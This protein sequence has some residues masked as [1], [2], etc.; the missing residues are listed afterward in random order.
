LC[1]SFLAWYNEEHRHSWIELLTPSMVHYGGAPAV[2]ERR[3][4]VFDAAYQANPERS[5]RSAPKSLGVPPGGLDQQ[6]LRE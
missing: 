6:T 5:V 1:Q 4:V 2:I 3:Q